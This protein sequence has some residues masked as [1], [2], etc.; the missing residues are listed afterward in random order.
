MEAVDG[1]FMG[2]TFE[3]KTLLSST[4]RFASQ[5]LIQVEF[6]YFLKSVFPSDLNTFGKLYLL[7]FQ[8][9]GYQKIFFK[10]VKTKYR[11]K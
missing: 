11:F 2:D 9:L 8:K 4:S 1:A 3:M 10:I 6:S 7:T 5:W